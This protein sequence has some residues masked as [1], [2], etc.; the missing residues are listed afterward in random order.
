M[1]V[2]AAGQVRHQASAEHGARL[3]QA[4]MNL[5][6]RAAARAALASERAALFMYGGFPAGRR[7]SNEA[8]PS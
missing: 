6:D 5:P 8:G 1:H 3:S 4:A 2:I 7:T